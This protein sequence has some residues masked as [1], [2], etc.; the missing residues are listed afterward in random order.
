MLYTIYSKISRWTYELTDS[1]AIW[2]NTW[3]RLVFL[4]PNTHTGAMLLLGTPSLFLSPAAAV[5]LISSLRGVASKGQVFHPTSTRP[6]VQNLLPAQSW[7]AFARKK[8]RVN[9]KRG[10]ACELLCRF[11]LDAKTGR[12]PFSGAEKPL[13]F[14]EK[15]I[16]ILPSLWHCLA[17]YAEASP[18][19]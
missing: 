2:W 5:F 7:R 11:W 13:L 14:V 18:K 9:W 6:F 10:S 12:F 19:L 3:V 8:T 16:T 1:F 4:C 17:L 15:T